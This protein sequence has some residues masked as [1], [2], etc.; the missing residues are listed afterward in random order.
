MGL[1]CDSCYAVTEYALDPLSY[2]WSVCYQ[3]I[4]QVFD[5]HHLFSVNDDVEDELVILAGFFDG[6]CQAHQMT[7]PVRR[8]G[9]SQ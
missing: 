2:S 9:S 3:A 5:S 8:C 6:N 1:A 4:V 7:M